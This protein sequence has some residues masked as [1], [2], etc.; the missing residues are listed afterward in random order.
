MFCPNCGTPV[1]EAH[2]ACP[3]CGTPTPQNLKPEP[4]PPQ[5]TYSYCRACGT[6]IP[7][8][9]P[10]CA[11][12]GTAVLQ[13]STPAAYPQQAYPQ[14]SYPQQPYPQQIPPVQKP[15]KWFKFLIYFSLWA[16]AVLTLITGVSSLFGLQYGGMS[17][18]V[19]AA[20]GAQRFV[21][22]VYGMICIALGVF[23][24]VTRFR[25]AAFRS[26]APAMLY[27]VYALNT[28]VPLIYIFA[29]ATVTMIPLSDYLDAQTISS[30]VTSAIMI[31]IN[32]IYFGKRRDMFVR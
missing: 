31:V 11:N 17:D 7:A 6:P 24:I 2:Q 32:V 28:I 26:N 22:I 8:G 23:M 12:C 27:G 29:T 19:Y 20:Y 10:A 1:P 30:I 21:D 16:G 13:Q 14:Q 4:T 25:L 18:Y 9:Q 15:M 3:S 5:Q